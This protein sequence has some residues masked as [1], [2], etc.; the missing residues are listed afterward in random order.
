[1]KL[2]ITGATG[3]IGSEVLHQALENP[4]IESVMVLSRRHPKV[5]N[6]KLEVQIVEDFTNLPQTV[7]DACADADACVWAL[8]SVDVKNLEAS[9]KVNVDYTLAGARAF[10]DGAVAKGKRFRLVYTSGILAVKDQESKPW[11]L[12]EA[13]KQRVS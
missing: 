9:R 7:L 4:S 13:R 3:F 10:A 1:M 8:G 5:E 12:G 2:I 6:H 11:F